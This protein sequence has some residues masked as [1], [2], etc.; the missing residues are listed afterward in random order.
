MNYNCSV[1]AH[2]CRSERIARTSTSVIP[3]RSHCMD[4]GSLASLSI[5]CCT[6]IGW[7]SSLAADHNNGRPLSLSHTF[8]LNYWTWKNHLPLNCDKFSKLTIFSCLCVH[9]F[10]NEN[11]PIQQSIYL[12][13]SY[14]MN[15]LTNT[16][17]M[18]LQLWSFIITTSFR[19]I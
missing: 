9:L 14:L 6:L 17:A 2:L 5:V 13:V 3:I 16:H 1:G 7:F 15:L 10:L 11:K 4:P 12:F 8:L 19:K 18:G